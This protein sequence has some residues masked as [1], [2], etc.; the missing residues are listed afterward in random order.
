M[1]SIQQC[2]KSCEINTWAD[3]E[4]VFVTS[5]DAGTG[6]SDSRHVGGHLHG[7]QG[8]LWYTVI[9]CTIVIHVTLQM[10]KKNK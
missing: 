7:A 1:Y 2:L 8:V 3:V 9:S 4:A 5:P 10:K 6:V